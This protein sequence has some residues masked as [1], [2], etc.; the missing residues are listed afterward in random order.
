MVQ[1][2]FYYTIIRTVQRG[3]YEHND[4]Y[5]MAKTKWQLAKR[6]LSDMTNELAESLQQR[7]TLTISK[8]AR[9]KLP[10]APPLKIWSRL[11]RLLMVIL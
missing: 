2:I 5:Q 4:K 3:L 11:L 1:Q 6:T 8:P 7:P 10:S 9:E